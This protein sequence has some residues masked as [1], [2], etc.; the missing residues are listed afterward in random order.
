MASKGTRYNEEQIIRILKEVETG[1]SVV[2]IFPTCMNE[3]GNLTILRIYD[4]GFVHRSDWSMVSGINAIRL[5]A[6]YGDRTV[7]RES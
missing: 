2:T 4:G 6:A 3:V 1:T 5:P 7:P